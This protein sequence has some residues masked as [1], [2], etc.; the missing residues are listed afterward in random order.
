MSQSLDDR[1]GYL[2]KQY[3]AGSCTQDEFNELLTLI[4][5]QPNGSVVEELL[6]EEVRN[7]RY[8]EAEEQ[9]NWQQMLQA[10]LQHQEVAAPAPVRSMPVFKRIAVAATI[11]LCAGA[12]ALWWLKRNETSQVNHH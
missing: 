7:S 1:T 2:L 4:H 5:I 10:V 3:I 12:I 11:I 6:L 8:H 9:V